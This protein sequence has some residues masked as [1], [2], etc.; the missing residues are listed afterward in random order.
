MQIFGVTLVLVCFRTNGDMSESRKCSQCGAELPPDAPGDHC[1]QCLLKLGLVT[2]QE[3]G[4]SVGPSGTIQIVPTSPTPT[5]KPGDWIGPYKLL[6]QIGEGGCGVVYMAEQEKPVHRRVALKVIKLGMDTKSVIARFEAERQALAMMDHPNIAKVLDAGATEAGRPYFVMELVRGIKITDY[7]DQNNLS[8]RER[9]DLFIQ[10]CRA[11]QHA[12]QKGII[13][14]DIKPSNIL[15]TMQDGVPVPK[16]IDFGIAKAT[17]G[18]LTDQTLFT[19]FEQ[20]IG[21]PAY[22]SPEQAE[23]SAMDIDTRSDI[24][25]LGVLLYELLTGKTPFDAKELIEA[26]LDGI[27]RTIREKEPARPSTRLS[28]MQGADLTIVARHRKV[29]A[30]KLVNLVRGDLDWIVMKTLEKDRTRRY[31]TANGLAADI[32]RHLNTE[33]VVA[34][35]PS[36]LYEFQ[37]TVHRHK[38]GFAAG[39][40]L[41]ASLL[42]G[43]GVS[44]WMFVQEKKAHQEAAAAEREQSRL[45]EAA[46]NAQTKE[47]Q[48]RQLAEAGEAAARRSAYASDLIAANLALEDGNFGLARTLLAQHQSKTNQGDLRGFEWR[49][50]WGKSRGEQLMTL[51]GHSNYV[52]CVAYSPDGK[53]LASGSSDHTVKLWNANTGELLATCAG[54]SAAVRSVAFSPDGKLFASG[55]EDNLVRLWDAHTYQIILTITNHSPYLAFSDSLLAI[56]TGGDMYGRDGGT[57]QLWNYVTGQMVADLPKSGNRA[58]FSPDGKTLA[59]A[60][61]RGLIQLWNLDDQKPFKSF[62]SASI[63]S[64]AFSPDGSALAWGTDQGVLG[65]WELTNDRPTNLFQPA[66]KVFGVAFSP[67]SQILATANENHTIALWN[68]AHYQMVRSLTGQGRQVFA[69]AFS[70]DGKSMAS[71]SLDDTIMVWNPSGSNKATDTIT[72]ITMPRWDEVLLPIFSPDGRNLAAATVGGGVRLLDT[73]TGQPNVGRDMDGFPVAFSPDG[74]R[75]FTRDESFTLLQQWDVATQSLLASIKVATPKAR[76]FDSAVSPDGKMIAIS[77]PHQIVLCSAITGEF[78]FALSQPSNAS[79]RCLTFSPDSQMVAAGCYDQT[80]KL[81]DLKTH[82]VVW[83]VTG[84]RDTV[85]SVAFSTNGFFAV[86]SWDGTI[87]V[88]DLDAKRELATLIGHKAGVGQL[89][90]SRDGRTL[91]SSGAST[92]KLWNLAVDREVVSFKIDVVEYF[93]KFSPDDNILA[94]GG[95]DGV[96]HFWRAPSWEKIAAKEGGSKQQ[97]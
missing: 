73:A 83:T 4:P 17:H 32:Q 80:A 50:L 22:M 46:Q 34:R 10:I 97:N 27:R 13:H 23:M 69:V 92:V 29:E 64:M 47:T 91:A 61:W 1:L 41:I 60:N 76:I 5:E 49:Y 74:K 38:F 53:M 36:R 9:L 56:G 58:A 40:A 71:G 72:N 20:F 35:P 43:L 31:E 85:S 39:G 88:Y 48:M 89:A 33:P 11:I 28:T 52:N 62:P 54:H 63:I 44:T 94:T 96:V 45:R 68:V 66:G 79:A 87:K 2:E 26:G 12:H 15:V 93:I 55:G 67:D 65:L 59:T 78:L 70:P 86:G 14:R 18:K 8:T 84:F 75:L 16:V 57:V 7:C 21:T 77:Q 51:T 25:S 81:W 82:E 24:Y 90:F 95:G 42:I 3:P 30:P 37:K 6:Q 19:A